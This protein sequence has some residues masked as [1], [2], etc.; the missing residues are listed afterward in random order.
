MSLLNGTMTAI[1]TVAVGAGGQ[2]AIEFTNIPQTYTDL[3]VMVSARNDAAVTNG[4]VRLQLNGNTSTSAY[5]LVYLGS[6]GSSN[7][8]GSESPASNYFWTYCPGDNATANTFGNSYYYITNY[9]SSNN[10]SI[11][12]DGTMENNATGS[13][14]NMTAYLYSNATAITSIKLLTAN[15]DTGASANFKQHSTATLYGVLAA[16]G[17]TGGKAI[18][19]TVTSDANY[20]YHTFTSSGTFTPTQ[21]INVD[22]LVVA[23]GGG[24]GTV[25]G[26]G[27]GAG[28]L[29]CTVTAT[30]RG[31]AL[32]SA[33]SLTA[34][35]KYPAIVGAGGAGATSGGSWPRGLSGTSSTFATITSTGG[36][37]GGSTQG[38]EGIGANGGCGGGSRG[39][40]SAPTTPGSGTANQGYDGGVGSGNSPNLGSGGG[41]G[42]GSGGGNG[43]STAGGN[44]GNGV[45]TSISGSSV[46]YAGGGGGASFQGGT[47]GSGGSGGGGAAG[48]GGT[49]NQGTAGTANRGGGG[50]GTAYQ[51]NVNVNGASGGSGIIII[52]YAK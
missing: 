24:S 13:R 39:G 26:A 7:F 46:T 25:Y 29:R 51:N 10:K 37:G 5:S 21:N 28:G 18:G 36:G 1:E 22:Y 9:T 43:T 30:G 19:G 4:Q 34:N 31:G 48:T 41:G 42:A 6:T 38:S 32:E 35:T 47:G 50:G 52:R 44:G 12:A 33:L 14:M 11:S 49:D 40:N 27:G 20:W 8:T 17:E 16:V 2:S 3:V 45:A 23:G 15:N